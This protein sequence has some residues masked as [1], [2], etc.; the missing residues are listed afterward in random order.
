[1][2][3]T[4]SNWNNLLKI[5]DI[6]KNRVQLSLSMQS[7]DLGTLKEIKRTNWTIK[8]YLDFV[9]EVK[10][11]GKLTAS[12]MI[13][14]LPKETENLILMVLNFLWIIMFKQELGV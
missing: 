3:Y 14:P 2:S 8:Q 5:N 12:E 6:L 13:I 11:R 1:M 10:K 4:K 9:N 7:L